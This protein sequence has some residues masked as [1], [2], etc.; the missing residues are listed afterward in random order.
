MQSSNINELVKVSIVGHPAV[1]KTTILK[2]LSEKTIDRM[3]MPTMGFDLKTVKFGK[4]NIK[5]WDFGGQKQFR[6]ILNRYTLGAKG[7]M[8]MFDLTR[9]SS[10]ESIEEWVNI[11]RRYE[12]DLPIILVGSKLD[13]SEDLIIEDKYPIENKLKFNMLAYLKTSAKTGENVKYAF[14][15][16]T[17]IILEKRKEEIY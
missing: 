3:Y 16:L 12:K 15:L 6:H 7:A 17:K 14:E 13:L 10:L 9:L 1:G 11:C 4:M 8:L 2:L 5:L